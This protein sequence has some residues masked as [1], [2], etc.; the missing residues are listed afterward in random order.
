MT[1]AASLLRLQE[2]DLAILRSNKRLQELPEKQEILAVRTKTRDVTELH[3][4]ADLLVHKLNHD[5]KAHQDEIASLTEKLA[6]EQE[7]VTATSDHRAAQSI[8]REM[9]GLRRRQDKLE[10]ESLQL[11]ERI[12]KA[13]AQIVKID[14]ALT[15][16]AEKD[17]VLV[18]QFQKVGG[19]LQKDIKALEKERGEV[20]LLLAKETLARYEQSRESKGGVGVGRLEGDQC[21]ACRMSLPMERVRELDAGPDIGTCPQ[22]RRLIVV[23][24]ES[25]E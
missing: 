24:T 4:K 25:P 19:A 13:T 2:L 18:A 14:E 3:R 15:Q 17:A 10:M 5:L 23:R 1:Q 16:L 21:S 7:K 20:A 6:T 9:D 22:C 11:M 12:E 8:T